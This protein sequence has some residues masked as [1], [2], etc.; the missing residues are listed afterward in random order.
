MRNIDFILVDGKTN[1]DIGYLGSMDGIQKS[2]G[3]LYDV[4]YFF[5]GNYYP[6]DNKSPNG[7]SATTV[8]ANEGY[9]KIKMVATSDTGKQFTE[10]QEIVVDKG[11]PRYTFDVPDVIEFEE[12]QKTVSISGSVYD[13]D[14]EE[15]KAAGMNI[16]QSANK[17]VNTMVEQDE[18]AIEM[19]VNK[20]GTFKYDVPVGTGGGMLSLIAVD[21]AG[22]GAFGA[23][24]IIKIIKK[25]TPYLEATFDKTSVKPGDTVKV[26]FVLKNASDFQ[27]STL[28]FSHFPEYFD[29]ENVDLHPESSKLGEM[30]LTKTTLNKLTIETAEGN[31]QTLNGEIPLAEATLKAKDYNFEIRP[32]GTTISMALNSYQNRS[33]KTTQLGYNTPY[34]EFVPTYSK[35]K[36][37]LYADGLLK[38]TGVFDST[39][40]YSKVGADVYIQDAEGNTYNQ[41]LTQY[42]R[43]EALRLPLTDQSLSLAVKVPGHFKTMYDFHIGMKSSTG[44]TIGQF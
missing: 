44:E 4:P 37:I 24:K 22:N 13:Q 7:I 28:N 16:D 14:I 34:I 33:G 30:K 23:P 10:V 42:G 32:D 36:S 3:V 6:F 29:V 26:K 43:I 1:K 18:P 40:D 27:K 12:G 41:L 5:N 19:L 8:V 38:S 21:P 9:Y 39:R 17:I 31:T 2:E 20:D 15:F 35:M 25:G 11:K